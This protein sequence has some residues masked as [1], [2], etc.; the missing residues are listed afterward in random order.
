M[1]V[2]DLVS[3]LRPDMYRERTWRDIAEAIGVE[4]FYK[5]TMAIGGET[6]YIPKPES[7]LRPVRDRHIKEE[8]NGFNHGE[9]AK[10]YDVTDLL[11]GGVGGWGWLL[12][13]GGG[14]LGRLLGQGRLQQL[15]HAGSVAFARHRPA[16]PAGSAASCSQTRTTTLA[17]V[18]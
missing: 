5:L 18:R 7:I 8:F 12:R 6:V 17:S 2:S 11:P 3:E 14:G 13:I 16:L 1:D 4:N 10:K 15:H 9:L